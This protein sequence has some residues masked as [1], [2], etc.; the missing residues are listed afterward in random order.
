VVS[1]GHV[2]P[3]IHST[4]VTD[5]PLVY[6]TASASK[7]RQVQGSQMLERNE[8][9]TKSE[10]LTDADRAIRTVSEKLKSDLSV[11]YTVNE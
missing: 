7:V 6:R 8:T 5:M 4:C 1:D 10:E 3:S 9:N 2:F 11:E